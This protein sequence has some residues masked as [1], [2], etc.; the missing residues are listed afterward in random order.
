MINTIEEDIFLPL[1]LDGLD[2]N[3]KSFEMRVRRLASKLNKTN[4]ALRKKII[5][6]LD[7]DVTRKMNMNNHIPEP[8]D[9]DTRQSLL[10]ISEHTVLKEHPIFNNKIEN[11]IQ[12]F[13]QEHQNAELLKKEGLLASRSLLMAGPPGVGKTLTANYLSEKLN[14][15]LL[16]LDLATVMSSY[17]GK[18]G[19]NI[20]SVLK[21]A[22]SFPCILFLDE[23]DAIAKKRDDDSDVGEL[24]R[25]VTVLLQAIDEWPD[26]SLLLAATNHEELLDR[27]VW[28]RFDKVINFNLPDAEQISTLL[29]IKNI[30]DTLAIW[31]SQKIVG[32][33]F[34]EIEKS[35]NHAKKNTLLEKKL[36]TEALCYQFNLDMKDYFSEYKNKKEEWI[37]YLNEQGLSQR[38]IS[39]TTGVSRT[40]IRTL[41]PKTA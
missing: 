5:S 40:K 16:T 6:L 11:E 18:T 31:L 1:L 7:N 36:F 12:R 9:S 28:R 35:I 13:L 2:G 23:F 33:S 10:R 15:P 8:V 34:S 17:L 37:V 32:L 38:K 27:A 21:Y 26:T 20:R 19:N 4:P 14:L 3:K 29:K 30:D 25:L 39:E 22:Q 24:K 41:L